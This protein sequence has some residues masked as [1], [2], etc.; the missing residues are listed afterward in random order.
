MKL[1]LSALTLRTVISVGA[2]VDWLAFFLTFSLGALQGHPVLGWV[3]GNEGRL[4]REGE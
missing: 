4:D 3:Q 2:C 1:K